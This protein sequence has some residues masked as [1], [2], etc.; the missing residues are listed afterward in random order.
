MN[1]NPQIHYGHPYKS[2]PRLA[3][4]L[5]PNIPN[6]SHTAP[7]YG[8]Y[9]SLGSVP[10]DRAASTNAYA[11][12]NAPYK[13]SDTPIPRIFHGVRALFFSFV[14]FSFPCFFCFFSRKGSEILR[15]CKQNKKRNY[16][17][18]QISLCQIEEHSLIKIF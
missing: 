18:F 9:T 12:L 10:I 1:T 15:E 4:Q 17:P 6:N 13:N 11:K 3:S 5:Y 8:Y 16:L 7:S 2:Q 14:V